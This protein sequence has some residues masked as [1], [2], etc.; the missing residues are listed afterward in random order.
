M[1]FWTQ[2][3]FETFI[4]FFKDKPVSYYAFLTLYWTG[5]RLGELLALSRSDF[6]AEEK[7]LSITKSYQRING[8]DVITEPKTAK[9]KRTITLPDFLVV[10]LEEYVSKL[11]GMMANDRLFMITKSYLEK[12]MA[13]GVKLSGV[14]KIRL[15]DL[16]HSHASLLISKLGRSQILLQSGLDMRKYRQ[17]SLLIHICT[18]IKHVILL[19]N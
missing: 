7:T 18:Q 19:S 1:Q 15:H 14:K 8:R 6:D 10:E 12:E 16:R 5:I 9:G 11:Y 13:R 17:R 2:E 3:E 4:R